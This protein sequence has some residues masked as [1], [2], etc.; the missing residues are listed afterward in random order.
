VALVATKSPSRN[1][2]GSR[3]AACDV[4]DLSV[5]RAIDVQKLSH[6]DLLKW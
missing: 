1:E 5:R 4:R 6:T 2:V 3:C